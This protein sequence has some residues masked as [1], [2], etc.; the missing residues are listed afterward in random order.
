MYPAASSAWV[1]WLWV[2]GPFFPF[3]IVGFR[4]KGLGGLRAQARSRVYGFRGL[5]VPGCKG[6]RVQEFKSLR[7]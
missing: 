6:A 1:D 4:V 5:R 7:V 2:Y 3:M